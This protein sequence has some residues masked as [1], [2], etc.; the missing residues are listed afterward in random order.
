L[1]KQPVINVLAVRDKPTEV[2]RPR[3]AY[4]A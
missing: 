4:S 1:Q 3:L 2:D